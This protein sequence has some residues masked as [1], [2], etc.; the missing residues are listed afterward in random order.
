MGYYWMCKSKMTLMIRPEFRDYI[1][2]LGFTNRQLEEAYR[3]ALT[4]TE[5]DRFTVIEVIARD[6]LQ[7]K[8][9]YLDMCK[10]CLYEESELAG[11]IARRKEGKCKFYDRNRK[12]N[13]NDGA[14]PKQIF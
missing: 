11:C 5:S 13:R 6:I 3:R 4:K 14:N 2:K 9:E 8:D 10:D 7:G 12:T 1:S